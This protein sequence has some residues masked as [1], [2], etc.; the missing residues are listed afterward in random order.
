[1][2]NVTT[3]SRHRIGPILLSRF[4]INLRQASEPEDESAMQCFSRFSV[5]AEFRVHTAINRVVGNIGEFLQFGEHEHDNKLADQNEDDDS[6]KGYVGSTE[7]A[8]NTSHSYIAGT[9]ICCTMENFE[10]NY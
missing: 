10:I 3:M 2:V 8:V 6:P 9:C 5:P 4:L 7:R 1:M